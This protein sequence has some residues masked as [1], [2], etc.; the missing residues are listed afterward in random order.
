MSSSPATDRTDYDAFLA[1]SR[2]R[3]IFAEGWW[4]DAATGSAEA[5]R[6][7]LLRDDAGAVRAAWPLATREWR[8]GDIGAG[9]RYTPFL[10]PQLPAKGSNAADQAS[11]DVALLDDLATSLHLYEHVEAACAPELDYWTPLHWHD[12]TQTTRTTWRIDAGQ[13]LDE[14]R[15][16]LRS[17]RKRNLKAA[18]AAEFVAGTGTIDDLLTACAA[19][20]ERQEADVPGEVVLRRLAEAALERGRGEVLT[21]RTASGELA[22]AGLF[23]FDD[24]WTWN[25]ANG[26]LE[27]DGGQRGAPTLLQWTAIEHALARGTGFDFEGSMIRPIERFVRGFGGRPVSYSV[28]RR[29]SPDWAR[30]VAR[31]RLVKRLLRR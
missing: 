6:P 4:L 28:V 25:L 13:S 10:G 16:G 21:V 11:A 22:S 8:L 15:A 5:W 30:T 3:T 17:E 23:V 27:V 26:H 2:Q 31:K 29:S 7:N 12:Y 18:T 20:F 14:V 1:T 24:R 19:T 9:A